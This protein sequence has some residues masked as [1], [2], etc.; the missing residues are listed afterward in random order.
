MKLGVVSLF[1]NIPIDL[2][3]KRVSLRWQLL[4][5]Q[6]NIPNNEF[7]GVVRFVL[8]STFF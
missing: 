6:C 3:I 4:D 1:I 7:V 5:K 2:A 8:D